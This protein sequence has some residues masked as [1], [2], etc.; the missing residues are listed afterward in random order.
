VSEEA[1]LI[2]L[3]PA[4]GERKQQGRRREMPIS[5]R[6]E[7][8]AHSPRLHVAAMGGFVAVNTVGYVVGWFVWVGDERRL[9]NRADGVVAVDD[10]SQAENEIDLSESA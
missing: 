2:G 5:A 10:S 9:R 1:F 8:V 7:R 3:P 4:K 6:I